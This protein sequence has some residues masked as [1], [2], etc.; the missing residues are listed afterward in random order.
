M[1]ARDSISTRAERT[2][3]GVDVTTADLIEIIRHQH[4]VILA[5]A[6][7]VAHD[8]GCTDAPCTCGLAEVLAV[9]RADTQKGGPAF[10]TH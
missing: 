6:E 5:L 3:N 7:H 8:A 9:V 10:L 2:G 4:E 1:R